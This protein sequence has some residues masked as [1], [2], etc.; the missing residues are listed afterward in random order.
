MRIESHLYS[1]PSLLFLYRINTTITKLNA[2]SSSYYIYTIYF[3]VNVVL[4]RFVIFYFF[5]FYFRL[6]SFR[7]LLLFSGYRAFLWNRILSSFFFFSSSL[8]FFSERIN[9]QTN[10]LIFFFFFVSVLFCIFVVVCVF[11]AFKFISYVFLLL[12]FS[13]SPS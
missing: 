1:S 2:A 6:K 9:K 10:D 3:I 11:S 5:I 13:L 4:F 8:L 12:N 7:C